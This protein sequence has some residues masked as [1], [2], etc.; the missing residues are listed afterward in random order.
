MSSA[1][2]SRQTCTAGIRIVSWNVRGAPDKIKRRSSL[3]QA[4]R[5]GGDILMLQ[6]THLLGTKVPCLLRYGFAQAFHA[7][8]TRGS[9]GVAIL[10]HKRVPYLH[11]KSWVDTQGRYL[12]I[13]GTIYG[14]QITL[15]SIYAP[16]RPYLGLWLSAC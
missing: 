14:E 4:K 16:P 12:F 2:T 8:F 11:N 15:G 13:Q 3:R 9:R 7:G 10:V 1:I 6:E 5:Y